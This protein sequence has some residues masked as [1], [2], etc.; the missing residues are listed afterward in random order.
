M[1][2]DLIIGRKPRKFNMFIKLF[3]VS[4]IAFYLI[5]AYEMMFTDYGFYKDYPNAMEGTLMMLYLGYIILVYAIITSLSIKQYIQISDDFF[6]YYGNNGFLSQAL[7]TVDI[8]FNKKRKPLI[9]IQLNMIKKLTLSY[10]NTFTLWYLNGHSLTYCLELYDGTII[11]INPDDLSLY[12]NDVIS[13]LNFLEE[14][15]I[16]ID[17]PYNLRKAL[18]SKNIRLADYIER[19]VKNEGNL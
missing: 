8:I 11:K 14:K 6:A 2:N 16:T 19:I 13:A 12:K 18:E 5:S 3:I 10:S 4:I 17:D 9:K 1:K 7:N 15:N